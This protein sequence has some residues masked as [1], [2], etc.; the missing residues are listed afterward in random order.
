MKK[1]KHLLKVKDTNLGVI[2]C[3]ILDM[4]IV[5]IITVL[6]VIG[7]AS[8]QYQKSQ[9]E[10]EQKIMQ[11]IS[12]NQSITLEK[13][14]KERISNLQMLTFFPEVYEMDRQTQGD[15]LKNR[16][17]MLQFENLFVVWADGV[18]YY[19]DED[20]CRDQ[21]KEPF[22]RHIMENDTFVTDPFYSDYNEQRIIVT[23][24]VSIYNEKGK[25][26][27][28]L[29]GA[30]NMNQIQ[31]VLDDGNILAH[32][33]LFMIQTDGTYVTATDREKAY[34]RQC[35]FEE[36][37]SDYELIRKAAEDRE[38]KSGSIFRNNEECLACVTAV[39]GQN[40]LIVQA[41]PKNLVT[42]ESIRLTRMQIF[43][44]LLVAALS[45]CILRIVYLWKKS[46]EKIY[47]DNLTKCNSRAAVESVLTRLDTIYDY[48]IAILYMDL[49]K[50][51]Y[52][53]DTYGHDKG[54][55]LLGYFSAVL[56]E[57]L[58]KEGMV[59]RVGGDEFVSVLLDVTEEEILALWAEV[60]KKLIEKSSLLDFKY[61]ISSSYGY[62]IRKKGSKES[63]SHLMRE[64]DEKMYQYKKKMGK[65]RF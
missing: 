44:E 15:F 20:L 2:D 37:N 50:F 14:F 53:N 5:L 8:N 32:S 48:D 52:V 26:V 6:I 10:D 57:V 47:T 18:G 62:V 65:A 64:A 12:K 59:G 13:F 34:S 38:S 45:Y 28:A 35:I 21:K 25:K 60:E 27:G 58:G 36:E 23:I 3:V 42:K 16:A 19:M 9:I 11:K 55:K 41:V 39:E 30:V 56:M 22:F 49:N 29:C 33:E 51:K 31:Q 1:K 40:L 54:D 61:T 7:Y 63:L 17:E 4:I 24:C 43:L 46:D